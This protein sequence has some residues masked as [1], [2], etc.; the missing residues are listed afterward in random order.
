MKTIVQIERHIRKA[1]L[2]YLAKKECENT[3]EIC[4]V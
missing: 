3:S 4:S 2:Q 1:L